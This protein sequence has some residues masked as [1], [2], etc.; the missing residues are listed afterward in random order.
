VSPSGSSGGACDGVGAMTERWENTAFLG[1]HPTMPGTSVHPAHDDRP[2]LRRLA[3][4]SLLLL[5]VFG[6]G[7]PAPLV[8]PTAPLASGTLAGLVGISE[9]PAVSTCILAGAL[10]FAVH[11]SPSALVDDVV[12]ATSAAP[13]F[14][15]QSHRLLGSSCD[16][17]VSGADV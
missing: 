17:P 1:Y 4:G 14:T 3:P 7:A 16:P 9:A 2:L 15:A 12:P 6:G 8:A 5:A 10:E 13:G 11:L